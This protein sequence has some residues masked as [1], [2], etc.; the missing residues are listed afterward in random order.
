VGRAEA[1]QFSH[2]HANFTQTSLRQQ[3]GKLNGRA[4]ERIFT[5][6][7]ASESVEGMRECIAEMRTD[8][9]EF[10]MFDGTR[11]QW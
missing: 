9:C 11:L 6:I 1:P 2:N 4:F 7:L 8:V 3:A 5:G 10:M